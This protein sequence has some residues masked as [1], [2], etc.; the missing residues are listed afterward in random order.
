MQTAGARLALVRSSAFSSS[1]STEMRNGAEKMK[2]VRVKDASF[3][4]LSHFR[5]GASS[6]LRRDLC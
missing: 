1:P 2:I 3:A 6:L 5:R 4:A